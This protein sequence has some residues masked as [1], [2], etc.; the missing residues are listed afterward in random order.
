MRSIYRFIKVLHVK[1]ALYLYIFIIITAGALAL[2]LFPVVEMVAGL[3]E[4]ADSN[5]LTGVVS[6]AQWILADDV[7]RYTFM[8]IIAVPAP[9]ALVCTLLFAG[10]FGSF[11]SGMETCCG[12]PAKAGIGLLGGYKKMFV[13]IFM[14]FF[15]VFVLLLLIIF[16]WIVSAVPL[17]VIN[18]LESRGLIQTAIL[19]AS[20]VLTI[21]V[22]YL[23]LLY[24]RV[25]A[26]SFVPALYSNAR[27]PLSSALAFA[28]RS[29]FRVAKY[30]FAADVVLVL[31][32]SLYNYLDKA[33]YM[34]LANCLISSSLIFMLFYVM[35]NTYAA[36]GYGYDG[37]SDR[38]GGFAGGGE[39]AGRGDK[40]HRFVTDGGARDR[41]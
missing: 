14:L 17:A 30:F 20:L 27:K 37:Y 36:E 18:E 10:T 33:I 15:A 7:A 25:Y 24:L 22:V 38:Y 34:L 29:F 41:Y 3:I 32:V 1:S 26:M 28:G 4:L 40:A 16:V 23:G 39:L 21:L 12:Y 19:N 13:Q 31:I 8:L 9:L 35:F 11:A 2:H 6:F 5:A